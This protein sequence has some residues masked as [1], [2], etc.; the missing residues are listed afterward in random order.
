MNHALKCKMY[1]L[2]NTQNINIEEIPQDLE[3]GEEFLELTQNSEPQNKIDKLD[4]IN[5]K[6]FAQ[7]ETLWRG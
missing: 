4:C 5:I 6:N 1:E 3:L 2:Q 7:L